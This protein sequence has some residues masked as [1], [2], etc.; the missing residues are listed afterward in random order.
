LPSFAGSR[1]RGTE[2]QRVNGKAQQ[3]F[4]TNAYQSSPRDGKPIP[5]ARL[6]PEAV[7]TVQEEEQMERQHQR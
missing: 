6:D 2:W 4:L 7:F 5:K 3:V 1:F